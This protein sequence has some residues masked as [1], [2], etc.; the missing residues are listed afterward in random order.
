MRVMAIKVN[1]SQQSTDQIS[2]LPDDGLARCAWVSSLV[3]YPYHDEEW[4]VPVH[5]DR[6]LFE[7]LLLEG[8]QAGLSWET[9][10]KKRDGYRQAFDNFDARLVASYGQDKIDVLLQDAGIIRNRLKVHGAVQNA[11]CFLSVQDE[12]GSFDAYLWGFGE[13]AP[14]V[15][16]WRSMD[17]VPAHTAESDAMSK[18]L[19]KRGFKFVGSTICYALMQS[20]GMVNDHTIDCFRYSQINAMG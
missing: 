5:D 11:R 4:G 2:H 15:N 18:D 20:V 10:L 1:M 9:I 7:M 6:T 16:A 17:E 8:A 3:S 12:Y 14:R 13:G 19:K